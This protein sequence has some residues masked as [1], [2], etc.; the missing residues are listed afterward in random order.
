MMAVK[1]SS[2][3]M[4]LKML[5]NL[6]G[7]ANQQSPKAIIPVTAISGLPGIDARIFV[8]L[9]SS[10]MST[11]TVVDDCGSGQQALI[12]KSDNLIDW[13]Y[14]S[15]IQRQHDVGVGVWECLNCYL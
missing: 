5:D 15:A 2:S 12:F 1:L 7:T 8:T 14:A 6:A 9:R 10:M 13:T 11:Q 3:L 4:V